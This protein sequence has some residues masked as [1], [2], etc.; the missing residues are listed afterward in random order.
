VCQARDP[1]GLY[2]RAGQLTGLTGVDDPYER[3][4][5]PDLRLCP[6]D[7][8]PAAQAAR[9]LALIDQCLR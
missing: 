9:V 6:E 7:G 1:K 5:S 8:D 4:L 3:P 2:A